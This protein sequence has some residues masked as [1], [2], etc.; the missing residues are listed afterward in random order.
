VLIVRLPDAK[1]WRT[2]D[3]L[4]RPQH[5]SLPDHAQSNHR[6]GRHRR[7]HGEKRGRPD[8]AEVSELARFDQGV[9]DLMLLWR[10]SP[11]PGERDEI[12]ADLQESLSD[13][14]DAPA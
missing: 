10:D 7:G 1:P 14:E 2:A 3:Y 9:F 4:E 8:I 13:Y 5:R 6:V 11:E 12:L